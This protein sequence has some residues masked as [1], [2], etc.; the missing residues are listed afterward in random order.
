MVKNQNGGMPF[1]IPT[2]LDLASAPIPGDLNGR[3]ITPLLKGSTPED[4]RS[5]VYYHFYDYGHNPV[6]V[7][8][9]YGL[10]TKRYKLLHFPKIKQGNYWELFDLSADPDELKNV[11]GQKAYVEIQET[12]HRQ[13]AQ[14]RSELNIDASGKR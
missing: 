8:E 6:E 13:L 7:P 4:W 14:R 3:S 2:F 1:I 11:Y 9:H 10:M 5:S 12:L